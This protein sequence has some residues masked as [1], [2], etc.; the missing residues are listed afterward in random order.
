VGDGTPSLSAKHPGSPLSNPAPKPVPEEVE[1][2]L[3]Y[4]DWFII[5]IAESSSIS[6]WKMEHQLRFLFFFASHRTDLCTH[7]RTADITINNLQDVETVWKPT[8][9]GAAQWG[10]GEGGHPSSGHQVHGS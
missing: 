3:P 7:L 5:S 1:K 2:G 6:E 4:L 8:S 10:G 9:N